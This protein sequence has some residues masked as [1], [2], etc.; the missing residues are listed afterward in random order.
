MTTYPEQF[1]DASPNREAGRDPGRLNVQISEVLNAVM[2]PCATSAGVPLSIV[3]MGL[4]RNVEISKDGDV[5]VELRLTT[6][7]C[8]E[9]V[10]KFSNE[11]EKG[12]SALSGVRHV[13]V[14][15]SDVA[16]WSE[17]DIS[18]EGRSKLETLREK[19]RAGAGH[20]RIAIQ[21]RP[22]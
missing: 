11:I 13:D 19:R 5:A 3:E 6:P 16:D 10:L 17:H 14:R 18:P 1:A 22:L 12:V 15:Y 8:I 21:S 4:V 2:D 7:G 20:T 9:G